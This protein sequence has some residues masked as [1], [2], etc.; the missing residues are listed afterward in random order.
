MHKVF[1]KKT[2]IYIYIVFKLYKNGW[3]Y[4]YIKFEEQ[5]NKINKYIINIQIFHLIYVLF[6][7][8]LQI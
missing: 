2:H 6:I 1:I 3:K 5:I 7:Y 4:T 8:G